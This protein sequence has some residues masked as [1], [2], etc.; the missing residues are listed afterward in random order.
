MDS[1]S[2]LWELWHEQ[3]KGL[4]PG[5]HGLAFILSIFGIQIQI[6]WNAVLAPKAEV[7]CKVRLCSFSVGVCWNVRLCFALIVLDKLLL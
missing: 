6:G 3:L 1:S 4:L 5:I 2:V 7:A